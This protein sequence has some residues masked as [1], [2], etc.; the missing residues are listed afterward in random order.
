[1]TAA[2]TIEHLN[3]DCRCITL[4]LDA[5]GRAAA[6]AVGDPIFCRDLAITH[7]NLLSRQPLFLT[8]AHATRM[9]SI[10]AAIEAV[11]RLPAYQAAVL[12][13]AP[14]IA[15][16]DP[17]PRSVF[18]GY[19]F[20]LGP[21]GP[22]LIEIN[23]N[24]GGALIDAYL[25]QAQRTCCAEMAAARPLPMELGSQLS[26]FMASFQTEW[27][28]QRR[29]TPLRTIAIV[30]QSPPMQ[31]L[32][33]EFVLF[34]RLFAAHG[35]RAIIADP[36]E[37]THHN[38]G[39]GSGRDGGMWVGTER[40]D[41]VYNRLT[42]FDFSLPESA[43]LRQAYLAGDVVVTPNPRT[44]AILA[45]KK[46]L[47]QL[48]DE[49]A[50]LSFGASRE[51]IATLM[52]GIP[53]TILVANANPDDLWARRS[54]LFF[55]PC[56]GYGGKAAYRGDKLTRKVWGD[57]LASDYVAQDLITPSARTI[58]IDGKVESLKA[59]LR[60]YTYDGAVLLIAARLYQGQTTNFRT[61]GGG[62]APVFIGESS[63]SHAC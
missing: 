41:L 8:S 16:F 26:A 39:D 21:D 27:G 47:A 25:L 42:D 31:Y 60:N 58:A 38:G 19:D 57:I 12:S 13:H 48:T 62:F 23:T 17:G 35:L 22:K 20:H 32:Y 37:L 18:M 29:T 59:D 2:Q 24:A 10:I 43:A 40:I 5:L 49:A 28:L 50:L 6:T 61:P 3:T 45:N 46:N 15:Q 55:K 56:S 1:M 52:A 11:A 51:T 4:D 44:H 9:R 36:A 33:P 7:P 34:E 53:R 63:S 14:A 30:D 54:G